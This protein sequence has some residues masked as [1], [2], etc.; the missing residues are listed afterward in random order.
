[1]AAGIKLCFFRLATNRNRIFF[2]FLLFFSLLFFFFLLLRRT[3]PIWIGQLRQ[4][5]KPEGPTLSLP[6]F[7]IPVAVGMDKVINEA[8]YVLPFFDAEEGEFPHR[9]YPGRPPPFVRFLKSGSNISEIGLLS[10][11]P[12]QAE[13]IV[14]PASFFPEVRAGAFLNSFLFHKRVPTLLFQLS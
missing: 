14:V 9:P 12:M 11:P 1:M 13:T 8:S 6:I 5:S 10:V 7:F 3:A 2:A 4:V